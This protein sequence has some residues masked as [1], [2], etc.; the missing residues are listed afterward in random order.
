MARRSRMSVLKRQRERKKAE[1]AARKRARRHGTPMPDL[2]IPANI[3]K[4]TPA[5]TI[6]TAGKPRDGEEN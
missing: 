4:L 6:E 5:G 1:K 2:G 3:V